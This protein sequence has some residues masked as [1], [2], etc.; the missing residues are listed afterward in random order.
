MVNF[1]FMSSYSLG[2]PWLVIS[3]LEPQGSGSQSE[4]AAEHGSISHS[5]LHVA[6]DAHHSEGHRWAEIVAWRFGRGHS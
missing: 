6:E 2:E 3:Q 4:A 5:P 1:N